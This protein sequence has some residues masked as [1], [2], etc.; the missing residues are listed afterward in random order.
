MRNRASQRRVEGQHT[1]GAACLPACLPA[2]LQGPPTLA[3]SP[4][5]FTACSWSAACTAGGETFWTRRTA[6]WRRGRSLACRVS[7]GLLRCGGGCAGGEGLADPGALPCWSAALRGGPAAVAGLHRMH[8]T[9][10]IAPA[11]VGPLLACWGA[12]HP[13]CPLS[14]CPPHH[15]PRRSLH[16]HLPCRSAPQR[17]R[18]GAAGAQPGA[19]R[20]AGQLHGHPPGAGAGQAGDAAAAGAPGGAAGAVDAAGGHD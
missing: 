15:T 19:G 3:P 14:A 20:C 16:L 8:P 10:G 17:A 11:A 18:Q 4:P 9:P 13:P 7:R 2:C 6:G 1:L 5:C 12:A